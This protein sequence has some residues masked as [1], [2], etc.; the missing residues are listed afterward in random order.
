MVNPKPAL[1]YRLRARLR[2]LPIRMYQRLRVW[3]YKLFL[4][5]RQTLERQG[6]ETAS[7]VTPV[8]GQ[9]RGGFFIRISW[10]RPLCCSSRR[11]RCALRSS[12]ATCADT[13]STASLGG[14]ASIHVKGRCP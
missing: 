10:A 3:M 8:A 5:I 11:W 14:F 9:R 1:L 12:A 7:A 2:L 6:Q 13:F 4:D